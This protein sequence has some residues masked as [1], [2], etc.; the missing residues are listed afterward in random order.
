MRITRVLFALCL[1]F[2]APHASALDVLYRGD[3]RDPGVIFRDG[4]VA[5]GTN[6]NVLA[7][8][9]GE[10]CWY[11]T[12][13]T[14]SAYISTTEVEQDARMYGAGIYDQRT[15]VYRIVPDAEASDANATF[16]ARSGMRDLE[17]RRD[18]LGL[19]LRLLVPVQ[20]LVRFPGTQGQHFAQGIPAQ[21]IQSVDIYE[22]NP[23]T[24]AMAFLRNDLNPRF[25]QP[26]RVGSRA[27]FT[28]SMID[29]LAPVETLYLFPDE[30][31]ANATTACLASGCSSSQRS[32]S[33]NANDR[34]VVE[35]VFLPGNL[36]DQVLEIILD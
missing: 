33:A 23:N 25:V 30:S 6:R 26:L 4:F 29:A 2:A 34:C 35:P 36:F 27:V 14:R 17:A 20:R 7:H 31:G 16:D 24:G 18:A 22:R 13:E 15:Y 3:S 19:H 5:P 9:S 8:I 28:P 21:W 10:S 11:G 1:F 32:L 12:V